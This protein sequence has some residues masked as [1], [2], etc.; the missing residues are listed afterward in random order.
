MVHDPSLQSQSHAG[1]EPTRN[2]LTGPSKQ[3]TNTPPCTSKN[4]I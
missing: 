4:W 3:N 1:K 2:T